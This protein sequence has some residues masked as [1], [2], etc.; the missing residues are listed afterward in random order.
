MEQFS[1]KATTEDEGKRLDKV[2]ATHAPRFS[3]SRLQS[4]VEG[5]HV[6]FGGEVMTN[7]A[8]KVKA[9]DSF[10]V[11]VPPA[12]EAVPQ[13]QDIALDIVYEDDDLLVINKPA[14]M[15]VHPAAGNHDGTLVNALLAH[16]GDS[17]S[18]IGGVKRPGIV[19]RLDKETSGLLVVAKNDAAHKGLSAQLSSRK[20][21][22]VY[23]AVVWGNVTPAQGRIETQIGRSKTNRKKM[24][25]LEGGGRDA[26]TDYKLLEIYG[27][28]ASL[29]E[30]RLQSGRTHQIRVH[31]AHIQHWLVGDPLYGRH[32]IPRFL[33][34]HKVPEKTGLALREFPRQ[35]LH[36]A[37]LEFIHPISENKI[38]LS[39]PLPEDMKKLLTLLRRQYPA[40]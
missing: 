26:I 30:C 21:K 15:V 13:A 38:S 20:L 25:V 12:V 4:L 8:Y 11:T 32:A 33:K 14:D 7:S 34:L 24:A 10:C 19:H 31:M 39:A 27:L 29:V 28:V 22:R 9:G 2:L 16:C 18:G 5:G 35:A 36:A 3:R 17:L 1:V 23:Q 6:T 40:P 37:Q